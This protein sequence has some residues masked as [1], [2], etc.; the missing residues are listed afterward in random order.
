M[1]VDMSLT[2]AE[3]VWECLLREGV[4]TVWGYP[5]GAAIP[6]YD[7]LA[8]YPQIHHVLVRHE[9]AAAHAADGY[10]RA[11]GKVGVCVATSGPGATNLVTGIATAI[12]DSSP[13]V[14]FTAQ[15]ATSVI[16]TDAFQEINITGITLPIT[17]HNY[18][19]R[20]PEDLAPT[21]RE[22]FFLAASGR[23]GPVLVDLPRDILVS[24][25]PFEYPEKVRRP[26]Y[27]PVVHGH[28]YQIQRAV[29]VIGDAKRPVV[30]GGHGIH[31]AKAWD[32]LRQF[33]ERINAPVVS[34]LLGLSSL[35]ADHP[36]YL[37]M[38]GMHGVAWA[39]LAIQKA[40][41]LIALGMRMDDRF[42]GNIQHFAPKAKVIHIDVDPAE[43]GKRAPVVVPIVGDVRH[44]LQALLEQT[45]EQSHEEWL[46]EIDAWRNRH[47]L[48]V[49]GGP[50]PPQAV[51]RTLH[52]M[53]RGQALVVSDVGQHQMWVAQHYEFRRLNSFF[54]S[55]GLGTM[56]YSLPAALGVQAAHPN[57]PVWVIVGDGSFQMNMQ[58]LATVVQE[59]LPIKVVILNNGYLGM[60][61]QWQELFH[62]A[63]YIG[64]PI[65]AP[66]FVPL[67]K[68]FGIPG[69]VVTSREN[70]AQ[71]FEGALRTDGP[72]L[73]D[74]R[75]DAVENVYPMV[76]PG[77]SNTDFVEDPR[78]SNGK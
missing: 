76:R 58:E 68:C 33:A 74:C 48:V 71:A 51:I 38:A 5:G 31:R 20:R 6:L 2:G 27:R 78:G 30:I 24:E 39:S 7:A 28:P 53:T 35:P 23:P 19:V 14:I 18:L 11:T 65:T 63:R 17:K 3:I 75:V 26:G 54:T 59:R 49:G 43:I 52:E 22:A 44:T 62:G 4:D 50:L 32:Q 77:T 12:M 10:A 1:G 47:P 56:G 41:L 60:V 13:M 29:Q 46:A 16:G 40:D 45:P 70:L 57:D 42:T 61:R 66:D 37:G 73:L 69:A 67:A 72:Y 34:T 36:L 25:C 9:Q 15:V 64:T 55:G 21:I 8:K